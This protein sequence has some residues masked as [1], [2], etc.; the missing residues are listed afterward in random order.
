VGLLAALVA[1]VLGAKT[2]WVDGVLEVALAQPFSVQ[3]QRL[4]AL[5]FVAITLGHVVI[6]LTAPDL[7]R[8]RLH[9]QA[10]VRQ[11]ERWG[12]LFFVAYPASSAWQWVQGKNA[13]WDNG[14]E[15]QARKEA[16]DQAWQKS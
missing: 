3:H 8:L 6:G 2:K 1:M 14:F 15:V 5:P 16:V 13:Y 4:Q 9:E 11:Y 10:H 12:P 7:D